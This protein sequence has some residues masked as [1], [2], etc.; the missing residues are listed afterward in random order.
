MFRRRIEIVIIFLL[1]L[2]SNVFCSANAQ[3]APALDA[4]THGALSNPV[5]NINAT[6]YPQA[7]PNDGLAQAVLSVQVTADNQPVVGEQVLAEVVDGD[8]KLTIESTET[9]DLGVAEFNFRMGIMPAP[10]AIEFACPGVELEAKVEIPLA[11]VTY[12]DVTLVSPE[13]YALY[14][15]RQASAAP[16]YVLTI[17]GFPDQLAADGAS[18]S[19]LRAHLTL[20][21]GTP[22]PGVPL[23]L[24]LASGEGELYS[25]QEA[26][27]ADGYFEFEFIAGWTPGTVIIQV[28]EPSTGLAEAFNLVLVEAGPARVELFYADPFGGGVQQEGAL[29][30]ADGFTALPMIAE[31]TDLNGIPLPGIEVKLDILDQQNGFIELLDPVS[32]AEGRVEFRYYAGTYEGQVRLRAYLADGLTTLR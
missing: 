1:A 11:A 29:L 12:L 28:V 17:D 26:T 5:I 21:D 10:A 14:M 18:L 2:T 3:D 9:N 6:C 4:I 19:R 16:I 30:P 15:E 22:A 24:G 25:E 23:T 27:D 20:V 8:G 13:E 32:D 7:L 31:V